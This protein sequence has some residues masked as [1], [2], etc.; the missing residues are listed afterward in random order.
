M[1]SISCDKRRQITLRYYFSLIGLANIETFGDILY[2]VGV[3]GETSAASHCRW[4][5]RMSQPFV[6]IKPQ[7]RLH[8]DPTIP[9]WRIVPID[10]L[11]SI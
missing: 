4:E 7:M 1:L 8:F 9:L 11:A 2:S 6:V 5:S 10:T 3:Y